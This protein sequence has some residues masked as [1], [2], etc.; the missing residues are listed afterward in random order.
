MNGEDKRLSL[1]YSIPRRIFAKSSSKSAVDEKE[2][3][4]AV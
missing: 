1:V 4:S 3:L 2:K